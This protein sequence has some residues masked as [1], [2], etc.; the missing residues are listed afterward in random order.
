M[1][2]FLACLALCASLSA[3]A[4][5]DNCTVLG[6]QELSLAYQNINSSIDSVTQAIISIA[7]T[8]HSIAES[9]SL[10]QDGSPG[11]ISAI[12][13]V[14]ARDHNPI[15]SHISPNGCVAEYP[16]AQEFSSPSADT[17]LSRL[18]NGW[19]LLSHEVL[20]DHNAYYYRA[21]CPG[22]QIVMYDYRLIHLTFA[23]E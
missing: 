11:E 8:L 14:V 5:D 4:Q 15:H 12:E 9:I 21:S 22:Q 1:K 7:D 17:V 23:K 19:D 10:A 2:R 6:V 20:S 13:Y 16:P 18:S 3:S